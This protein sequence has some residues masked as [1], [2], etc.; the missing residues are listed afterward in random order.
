MRKKLTV[1]IILL[2]IFLLGFFVVTKNYVVKL[3]NLTAAN[4]SGSTAEY[5]NEEGSISDTLNTVLQPNEFGEFQRLTILYLQKQS[6]PGSEIAV[7]REYQKKQNYTSYLTSYQSEGLQI[8][9][10]LTIP[11]TQKPASG[12]P[13]IVFIHGYIPPSTYQTTEKYVEYVDY[14]ARNGF[15]VFKIDLRGHGSSEGEPGGA[16][17][18]SDYIY[19][20]LNAVASLQQHA[21]VNPDKIGM[22]GH[23]MAGNVTLRAIAASDKVKAAVIWGG[24]VYTY[25]DMAEYGIDDNSYRPPQDVQQR[26]ERQLS[27]Q[28]M[29]DQYGAPDLQNKFWYQMAPINFITPQT[30][31]IQL[32]HAIN[33]DVVSVEYTRNLKK[34]LGEKGVTIEA[35][36]YQSGGHN[37]T[38]PAF[39]TA[40]QRTVEFYKNNL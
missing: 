30:A 17:Y 8:N 37:I 40:M 16:Y 15:V 3:A 13:A 25:E 2:A 10:L 29:S 39:N 28:R 7:E 1:L 9:G 26:T 20:A 35:Y 22:W 11:T 4:N 27:R 21:D 34:I 14:L 19:D 6:F 32:H 36:E 38:S 31:P 33:D 12:Y 24:A 23:S 5:G 18:S